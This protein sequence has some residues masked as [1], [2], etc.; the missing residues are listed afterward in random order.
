MGLGHPFNHI[1]SSLYLSSIDWHRTQTQI[2]EAL[3][4]SFTFSFL[5]LLLD[6]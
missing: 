2:K 6:F 3:S 1:S 4:P 5:F